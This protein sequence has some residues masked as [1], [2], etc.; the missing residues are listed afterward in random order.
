MSTYQRQSNFE[1]LRML[2][3]FFIVCHHVITHA[4]PINPNYGVSMGTEWYVLELLNSCCFIAVNVFILISG[5][6]GINIKFKSFIRLYIMLAFYGCL[7]YHIHLFEIE[8]HVNR[9]SIFNTLFPISN[10]PGWWFI[11]CYF[12]LY[13]ISPLLNTAINNFSKKQH[14][15]VLFLLTIVILYYGF[16]EVMEY[17]NRGFSVSN[18]IYLYCIGGYLRRYVPCS[19]KVRFV[20]ITIFF[21][22]TIVLWL[23]TIEGVLQHKTDIWYET[24]QYNH[25][26]LIINAI[27]F[28]LFFTTINIKSKMVNFLAQ[29]SLAVYL[30]HANNYIYNRLCSQVCDWYYSANAGGGA[31]YLALR[32]MS[33]H[34]EHR[35]CY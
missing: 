32:D 11:R 26:L 23:T 9:W 20:S 27:A 7:L 10:A 24:L 13:L 8:S 4:L 29:S 18:F 31:Y 14:Q 30:I 33:R 3:M 15:A 17:A 5:Y 6:F 16:Y 34:M 35:I 25:P 21:I 2:C 22:G 28:F 1:L 12:I 19:K